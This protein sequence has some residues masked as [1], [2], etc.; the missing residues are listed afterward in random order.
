MCFDYEFPELEKNL[1]K[2]VKL[3]KT[4][5]TERLEEVPLSV[6]H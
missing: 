2:P 1:M 4:T 6:T 5:E 3:K